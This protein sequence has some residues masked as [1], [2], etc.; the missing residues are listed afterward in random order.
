MIDY[1]KNAIFS[2]VR[3]LGSVLPRVMPQ[4]IVSCVIAYVL[5]RFAAKQEPGE[6]FS[7]DG[8]VLYEFMTHPYVHQVSMVSIGLV[9]AFRINIAYNRFWEGATAVMS[10]QMK[11]TSALLHICAFD[12]RP[13]NATVVPPALWPV[14]AAGTRAADSSDGEKDRLAFRDN[15][16]HLFSLLHAVAVLEIKECWE[17]SCLCEEAPEQPYPFSTTLS[18]MFPV[19]QRLADRVTPRAHRLRVEV[20]G[21]VHAQELAPLE[22]IRDHAWVEIIS[23]RIVRV[24]T[25]RIRAGGLDMPPPITARIFQEISDGVLACTN[26]QKIA[27]VPFPYALFELMRYIK[28]YF[29]CSVPVAIV[30]FTHS[31]V[32]A[33]TFSFLSSLLL[34]ALNEVA[35]EL[36]DPFGEDANDLPLLDEHQRFN[37]IIHEMVLQERLMIDQQGTPENMAH[38]ERVKRSLKKRQLTRS[39]SVL[40]SAAALARGHG[41]SSSSAAGG[42]GPDGN[43]GVMPSVKRSSSISHSLQHPRVRG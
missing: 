39:S 24:L 22:K 13:M 10:M 34:V 19:C 20:L 6:L 33:V 36:E 9:V 7:E 11:W 30:S 43:V 37:E 15:V 23:L 42:V 12:G 35:E 4:A 17:T 25:D 3:L 14:S 40:E 21:G 2:S 38:Q 31:V 29:I 5:L 27:Q 8:Y 1:N 18:A 32:V 16:A 28:W 26:A 41:A